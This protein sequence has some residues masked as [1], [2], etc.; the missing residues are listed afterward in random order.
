MTTT[1]AVA[2]LVAGAL[3]AILLVVAVFLL[4][5]VALLMGEDRRTY[6]LEAVDRML[7]LA[8][9]LVGLEPKVLP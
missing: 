4:S 5:L 2:R 9:V 6:A 8:A 7:A 1:L 3:P